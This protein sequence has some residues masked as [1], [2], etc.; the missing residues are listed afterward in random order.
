MSALGDVVLDLL[1]PPKCMLCGE[2]LSDSDETVCRNCRYGDLP[3][4]TGKDRTIP[5]FEMCTAPFFYEEPISDA[6]RRMKFHG[7]QSYVEQFAAWM[8]VPVRDQM[9][10]KID[11]I[12]WVPCSRRRVWTRGFDQAK[13]LAEALARDLQLEAC[14]T[15]RKVKHNAKQSKAANAAMRR[16]NVLGVYAAYQPER[17][18]GKRILL[19]DDVVTTGATMSECGKVLKLAGSGE[20]YCAAVAAVHGD[21]NE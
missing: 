8:A 2:L 12:S 10:G 16:A 13:L 19:V 21:K 11:L 20:L 17:F 3:E 5:Y 14:C 7:M 4:Y 1:Y 15:L 9:A 6:I 18:R